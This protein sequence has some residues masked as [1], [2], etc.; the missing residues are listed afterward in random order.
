MSASD[1]SIQ[2]VRPFEPRTRS[3]SSRVWTA[4]SAAEI[5]ASAEAASSV[6]ARRAV[7]T[8]GNAMSQ[9]FC[10]TSFRQTHKTFPSPGP[11]PVQVGVPFH[12]GSALRGPAK[13]TAG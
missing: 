3:Q 12:K 1:S 13:Q 8:H 9:D 11:V 6:A 10:F 5:A 2:P 4:T 7:G